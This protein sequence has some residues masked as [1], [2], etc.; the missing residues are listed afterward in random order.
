MLEGF[1][2]VRHKA[3][4]FILQTWRFEVKVVLLSCPERGKKSMN[5]PGIEF[6]IFDC[7]TRD[8]LAVMFFVVCLQLLQ[9]SFLVLPFSYGSKLLFLSF[10]P[11]C[12]CSLHL[13]TY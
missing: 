6:W 1:G 13:L 10:L 11:T 2:P 3:N 9:S 12:S 5:G 7:W 4:P 8:M